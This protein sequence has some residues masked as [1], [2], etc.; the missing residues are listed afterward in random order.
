MNQKFYHECDVPI[1]VIPPKPQ[2]HSYYETFKRSFFSW[3]LLSEANPLCLRYFRSERSIRKEKKRH[4]YSRYFFIMHPISKLSVVHDIFMLFLYMIAIGVK[5]MDAAYIRYQKIQENEYAQLITM[6]TVVDFFSWFNIFLMCFRG[7][8]DEVV[9]SVPI[10]IICNG[11]CVTIVWNVYNVS[12]LIKSLLVVKVIGLIGRLFE[13]LR[14]ESYLCVLLVRFVYIIFWFTHIMACLSF[15]LPYYQKSLFGSW[16]RDT[17]VLN[18]D[19]FNKSLRRQYFTSFF[20]A[21]AQ[22]TGI[23][24]TSSKGSYDTSILNL[25]CYTLGRLLHFVFWVA[26]LHAFMTRNMQEVKYQQI[27][28]QLKNWMKNKELPDNLQKQMVDYYDFYYRKRYFH[29]SSIGR[30]LSASLELKIRNNKLRVLKETNVTI[31][32]KLSDE[33]MTKVLENFEM[34]VYCPN[35]VIVS[36][37]SHGRFLFLLASGTVALYTYSG[38]EVCHLHDGAYFGELSLLL[39]DTQATATI[40]A[41][42]TSKIYKLRKEHFEKFILSNKDVYHVFLDEAEL[43]L[44]QILAAEEDYRRMMFSKMYSQQNLYT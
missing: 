33:A 3:I 1:E 37:G 30:L 12:A 16:P 42:E 25:I 40:I 6:I 21:S 18:N 8:S 34:E 23:E 27:I 32:G 44:H 10:Y 41:I 35:D 22:I 38:R 2:T 4:Y 15:A 17:W 28:S 36:C 26:I 7:Y 43:R 11:S 20:R 13:Y 39:K 24:I 31:F 19:L 14:I 5:T 9:S 29:Q